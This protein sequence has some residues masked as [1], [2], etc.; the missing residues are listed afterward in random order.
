MHLHPHGSDQC[1][2]SKHS[3]QAQVSTQWQKNTFDCDVRV[4][5][6]EPKQKTLKTVA[7]MLTRPVTSNLKS[8]NW[9]TCKDYNAST[10]D[11]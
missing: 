4:G 10:Y 2:Q 6:D 1:T 11:T 7:A 9:N 3:G 8:S 5:L